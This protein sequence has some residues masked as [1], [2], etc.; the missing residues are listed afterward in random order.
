MQRVTS[1]GSASSASAGTDAGEGE[2]IGA[3]SEEEGGEPEGLSIRG[4]EAAPNAGRASPAATRPLHRL[5]AAGFWRPRRSRPRRTGVAGSDLLVSVCALRTLSDRHGLAALRVTSSPGC[6]LSAA[7]SGKRP[8][9]SPAPRQPSSPGH[10]PAPPP[11]V[12]RRR[13]ARV[14]DA[15]LAANRCASG[16]R[17]PG[18]APSACRRPRR[19]S[20][21]RPPTGTRMSSAASSRPPSTRP[22]AAR[23]RARPRR[24]PRAARRRP[25]RRPPRD[26]A[27]RDCGPVALARGEARGAGGVGVVG[28]VGIVV[29]GRR[30]GRRRRRDRRGR[31]RRR[32]CRRRQ[33]AA[34][35]AAARLAP[36]P[37]ALV[38]GGGGRGAGVGQPQLGRALG[39]ALRVGA[40]RRHRSAPPQLHDRPRLDDHRVPGA[41]PRAARPRLLRR[42]GG[43]SVHGAPERAA[44]LPAVLA[45]DGELRLLTTRRRS[46]SCGRRR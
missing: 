16:A 38:V 20:G 39:S 34:H 26:E 42:H 29:H 24:R 37:A 32:H 7:W 25:P 14:A 15:L 8:T 45:A 44:P 10:H 6:A 2:A 9:L 5:T 18:G 30:G 22:R 17:K 23:R 3:S 4:L 31:R 21:S 35:H 12:R 36:Q 46:S 33:A 40:L 41:R 28:V 19:G 1:L 11:L 13:R 43:A 27:G